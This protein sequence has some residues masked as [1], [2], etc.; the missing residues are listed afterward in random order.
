ARPRGILAPIPSLHNPVSLQS[1]RR[2][3]FP[4]P[5]PSPPPGFSRAEARP[6][7]TSSAPSRILASERRHVQTMNTVIHGEGLGKRYHR[8]LQVDDGLRHSLE[9]FLRSP[10]SSLRRKKE[11]TFWALKDCSLA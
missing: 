4:L 10:I 7:T 6:L 5:L 2:T 1:L 9:A 11:E 3:P 8:G